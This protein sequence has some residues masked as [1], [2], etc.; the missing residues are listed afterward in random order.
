M[1]YYQIFQGRKLFHSG[2]LVGIEFALEK[3]SRIVGKR[4]QK[5]KKISSSVWEICGTDFLL[6]HNKK[7]F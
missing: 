5:A 3:L 4:L 2:E 1:K 6:V 7:W